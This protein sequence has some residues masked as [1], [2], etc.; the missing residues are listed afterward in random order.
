MEGDTYD[1]RSS[2]RQTGSN[3]GRPIQNRPLLKTRELSSGR[4]RQ[5][6][7]TPPMEC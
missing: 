1:E 2:A 6:K 7:A 3:M 4:S 5:K